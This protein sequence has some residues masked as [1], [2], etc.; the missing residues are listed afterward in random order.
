MRFQWQN[1]ND[2]LQ[3]STNGD[4]QLNPPSLA[5]LL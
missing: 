5:L 2:N 3:S 4:V 1:G